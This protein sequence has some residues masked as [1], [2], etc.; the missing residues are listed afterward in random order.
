MDKDSIL[1]YGVIIDSSDLDESSMCYKDTRLTKS[2]VGPNCT[3]GDRTILF[4]TKLEGGNEIRRDCY[5]TDSSVGYG[6][7]ISHGTV[8][9]NTQIGKYCS[10]SWCN[11]MGGK[12]HNYKRAATISDYQFDR[13][14]SG[15]SKIVPSSFEDTIIG[16]DVWIGN[17]A[18]ILRGIKVGDG[19]VIGA[20]AVVTKDVEPYTI[21]AGCPAKPIKKRHDNE[22]HIEELLRIKWWDWNLEKIKANRDLLLS[23]V[24]DEMIEKLKEV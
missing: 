11:S 22:K 19:A 14:F 3:V 17:G 8:I 23:E 16:N 12:N 13:I 24:N 7:I 9:K 2:V 4:K 10:I 1:K 5:I 21:V 15:K 20:G 6:T 18:I